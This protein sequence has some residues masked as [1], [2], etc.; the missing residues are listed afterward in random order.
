MEYVALMIA[1][2]RSPILSRAAWGRWLASPRHPPERGITIV[3]PGA[4]LKA[5]L[6]Q[7][8]GHA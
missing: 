1:E 6:Q 3:I 4:E 5:E 2:V 8:A 7:L